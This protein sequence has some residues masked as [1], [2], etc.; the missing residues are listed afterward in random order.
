MSDRPPM[1]L[2]DLFANFSKIRNSLLALWDFFSVTPRV[3]DENKQQA[4]CKVVWL[5]GIGG[6]RLSQEQLLEVESSLKYFS[7][8]E[9]Q[10]LF[11]WDPVISNLLLNIWEYVHG[12]AK[13]SSYPWNIS[14]PVSDI[15]NARCTFCTSWLEGRKVLPVERLE[16]FSAVLQHAIYVGLVGHGEPL[17]HPHFPELCAVLKKFL[18]P[19]STCYTITNGVFLKKWKNELDAIQLDS[20]SISL[21]A[22]TPKT[23]DEIMGLGIEAFSDITNSIEQL[24]GKPSASGSPKQIYITMVI[25]QQN[26]EE[27]PGFI[28]LGNEL[29]VTEIWLRTLLP[30]S[31]LVQGLNYHLLPPYLHP[32]FE[33]LRATAVEAI[34]K[35]QVKIQASP[36]T[37]GNS[38]FSPL[39]QKDIHDNPP[40]TLIRAEVLKSQEIRQRTKVLYEPNSV[41]LFKGRPKPSSIFTT[42]EWVKGGVRIT[43][44]GPQWAHA[45]HIPVE[46]PRELDDNLEIEVILSETN[47]TV[48]VGLLDFSTNAWIDRKFVL[49]ESKSTVILRCPPKSTEIRL[50]IENAQEKGAPSQTTLRSARI[51][52]SQ[53]IECQTGSPNVNYEE[54]D[55]RKPIVHN[56]LDPVE[57]GLNPLN[58]HARFPCKA[59]YYNLYINELFFRVNPCCYMTEV[60]GFEEIR[61]DGGYEFSEAWNS[62][63]MIE[64][65]G[66]LNDGPLLGSCQRCPENW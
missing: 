5:L 55:I 31:H 60:P 38:I 14:L 9:V 39:L 3:P 35:S 28:Q 56:P 45:V 47:G 53:E 36:E 34:E 29:G 6:C 16:S 42:V 65:R 62:P 40:P 37:W 15:C 64:L 51:I 46:F 43:T 63:A 21:N 25:T 8:E 50:V 13:L 33:E 18:D 11:A 23:H 54:I 24:V 32:A 27:I 20:Y 44:P 26:I 2:E 48:G 7:R 57:D 59:V 58:R 41:T 22:A 12:I 17:A 49:K 19:R 30:Q 66:R 52:K 61:F 10:N 1:V 4:L